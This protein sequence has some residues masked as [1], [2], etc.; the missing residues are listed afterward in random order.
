[1][2]LGLI[3]NFSNLFSTGFAGQRLDQWGNEAVISRLVLHLTSAINA[4]TVGRLGGALVAKAVDCRGQATRREQRF[5]PPF[6]RFELM[7]NPF[8]GKTDQI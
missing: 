3:R 6:A 8:I 1:V 7:V 4:D 2:L 5:G